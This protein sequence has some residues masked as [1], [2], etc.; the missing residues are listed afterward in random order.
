MRTLIPKL[1]MLAAVA[2]GGL[3]AAGFSQES[4]EKK[5][6]K[7]PAVYQLDLAVHEREDGARVNTRKYTVVLEEHGNC[8]IRTSSRVPMLS[9]GKV[10]YMDVGLNIDCDDLRERENFVAVQLKLDISSFERPEEKEKASGLAPPVLRNIRAEVYTAVPVSKPT[11]VSSVEDTATKR[12]YELEV[13]A[14][15][16][17]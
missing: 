4:A 6:P 12:R 17:K 5:P 7:P 10:I 11:V 15:K 16:L 14:V 13:T 9:E 1:L 8:R 3:V 2:L